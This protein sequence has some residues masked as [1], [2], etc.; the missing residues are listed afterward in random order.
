MARKITYSGVL[1]EALSIGVRNI[2]PL[3]L[4][5]LLWIVTIIIPYINVGTTIAI[6][7]LPVELS[8]GNVINPLF[9]FK[10]KYRQVMGDY[11]ILVGRSNS[12]GVIVGKPKMPRPNGSL[13]DG[14]ITLLFKFTDRKYEI[15]I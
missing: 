6:S 2:I 5:Y 3:T 4:T 10:S 14:T 9:I 13:G 11:F 8:R 7:T 1:S 12:V 15:T